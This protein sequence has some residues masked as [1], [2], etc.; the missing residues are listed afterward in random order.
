MTP[1][2]EQGRV[3]ACAVQDL[4]RRMKLSKSATGF[5][6]ELGAS[7]LLLSDLEEA[8]TAF[9][10]DIIYDSTQHKFKHRYICD[11]CYPS[12]GIEG[13]RFICTTCGTRSICSLCMAKHKDSS[14]DIP[15]QGHEFLQIPREGW[16]SENATS[17]ISSDTLRTTWLDHLAAKYA[18]HNSAL[19]PE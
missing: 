17:L 5:L 2:S 4:T 19:G 14:S 16:S 8:Y 13:F 11:Q 7:L 18:N 10:Q 1:I 12:D 15:C 6:S 9:E 3:L